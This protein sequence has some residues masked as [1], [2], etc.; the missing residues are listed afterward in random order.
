MLRIL[1]VSTYP[2]QEC[3]IATY[4]RALVRSIEEENGT[5]DCMIAVPENGAAHVMPGK[6]IVHVIRDG[7][8]YSYAQAAQ[9]INNSSCDVVWLQHEFGIFTGKWGKD[10][11]TLCRHL[12]KPIV[13]TL[14]TVMSDPEPE[15]KEVKRQLIQ[16]SSAVVVMAKTA[17]TMLTARYMA[18]P[19]KLHMIPHGAPDVPFIPSRQADKGTYGGH[20]ILSTFG[21]ISRGK[22]LENAISA[23]PAVVEEFPQVKYLIIG[24]THPKI[25]MKE[26]ESYRQSLMEL[27]ESLGVSAHVEFVDRYMSL[28]ELL[29]YLRMTDVYVTPYVGK[30]QI[31]SGTLAYAVACGKAIV[32]TP[33]RYAE[34]ML[35]DDR[36][37]LVDFGDSSGMATGILKLLRDPV[38]KEEIEARCHAFS[39][40]MTWRQVG[41]QHVSVARDVAAERRALLAQEQFVPLR[42]SAQAT[43]S[44]A[45]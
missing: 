29:D 8:P 42:V 41:A 3:G 15:A 33:Y 24:Q 25:L 22:G 27:A 2:P 4:T 30:E 36:G 39:R 28:Q 19:A 5:A 20:L 9:L 6:K 37:I 45:S 13:M 43:T 32:S 40:N 18:N 10:V 21:L 26:G 16:M 17:V 34:E 11:V 44:R 35:A 23:L 31:V 1:F 7:G 14:H 12:K 38:L